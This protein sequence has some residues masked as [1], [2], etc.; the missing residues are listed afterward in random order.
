MMLPPLT[1][2]DLLWNL[3]SSFGLCLTFWCVCATVVAGTA[4]HAATKM[5]AAHSSQHIV[6][7]LAVAITWLYWTFP[8]VPMFPTSCPLH[9]GLRTDVFPNN[10][11]DMIF[12]SPPQLP[13]TAT[14]TT[15]P[16][17][18]LHLPTLDLS[19]PLTATPQG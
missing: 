12:L 2:C 9:R 1:K 10:Y 19:P 6:T 5:R 11:I 3:L 15:H 7:L 4:L 16:H 8:P 13:T 18:P 14:G 17:R